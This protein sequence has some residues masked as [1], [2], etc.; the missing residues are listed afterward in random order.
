M[1]T[2]LWI[3]TFQLCFNFLIA[4]EEKSTHSDEM[5]NSSLVKTQNLLSTIINSVSAI[6]GEWIQSETDFVL[7]GP[8]PILL[9][10]YYAGDQAHSDQ[11]GYN[12]I[13]TILVN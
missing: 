7:L 3:F 10:R 11:L 9:N 12:W 8:E 2:F 1:R 6:S 5:F 4:E 13:S